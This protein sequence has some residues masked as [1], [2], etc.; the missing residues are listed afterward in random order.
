ME[1][2]YPEI[3][4]GEPVCSKLKDIYFKDIPWS[5]CH[6]QVAS[7]FTALKEIITKFYADR[8]RI[9]ALK[10]LILYSDKDIMDV[11]EQK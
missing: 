6:R 4:L 10:E 8:T 7:K 5:Q 1:A 2:K 9:D 3:T 11:F